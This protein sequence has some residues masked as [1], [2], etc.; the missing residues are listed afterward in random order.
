MSSTVVATRSLCL[1]RAAAGTPHAMWAR[2]PAFITHI[3]NLLY[4]KY[5]PFFLVALPNS[6][7]RL[8]R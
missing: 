3:H 2:P 6:P 8:L 1:G 5:A 4:A 7:N